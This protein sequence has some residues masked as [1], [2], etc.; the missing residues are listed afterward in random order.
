VT[1]S[2][3]SCRELLAFPSGW[4]SSLAIRP[5]LLEACSSLRRDLTPIQYAGSGAS[6]LRHPIELITLWAMFSVLPQPT[7]AS[8]VI[9]TSSSHGIPTINLILCPF[10]PPLKGVGSL[11]KVDKSL[12]QVFIINDLMITTV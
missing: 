3:D 5:V 2:P 8:Q 7:G 9:R 1:S 11:G 6:R 4:A 10:I 12:R